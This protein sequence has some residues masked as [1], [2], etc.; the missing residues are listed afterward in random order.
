MYLPPEAVFLVEHHENVASPEGKSSILRGNEAVL[1][2]IEVKVSPEV[3]LCQTS[4]LLVARLH[5]ND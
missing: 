4:C 3:D 1:A 2:R 5:L